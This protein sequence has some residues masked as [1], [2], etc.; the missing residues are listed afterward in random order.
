MNDRA[1]D[2]HKLKSVVKTKFMIFDEICH[3]QGSRSGLAG[4]AVHQDFAA[5]LVDLVDFV[6]HEVKVRVKTACYTVLHGNLKQ[7]YFTSYYSIFILIDRELK[8]KYFFE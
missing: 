5:I 7:I 3:A 8:G 6:G 2:F 1:S 4:A